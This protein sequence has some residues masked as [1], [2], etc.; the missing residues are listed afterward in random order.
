MLRVAAS[1]DELSKA[2]EVGL[3]APV[4]LISQQ[5]VHSIPFS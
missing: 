1:D 4:A 3:S 5:V 2:T